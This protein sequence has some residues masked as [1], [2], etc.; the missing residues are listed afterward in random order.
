MVSNLLYDVMT[1]NYDAVNRHLDDR[2]NEIMQQH[3]STDCEYNYTTANLNDQIN[4]D[5]TLIEFIADGIEE[6]G[7]EISVSEITDENI[8]SI[9]QIID[10]LWEEVCR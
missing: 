10:N 9:V 4:E 7:L 3:L 1:N 8:N 5:E 6:F 2:L